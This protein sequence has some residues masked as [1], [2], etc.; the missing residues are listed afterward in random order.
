M[1]LSRNDLSVIEGD[2]RVSC[3]R[4]SEALGFAKIG[5]LHHLIKQHREELE[6]FG[7]LFLNVQKKSSGRGRPTLSYY[8]NEHQAVAICLWAQTAKAREARRQIIDVF[9]AWRHGELGTATPVQSTP[10]QDVFK[11]SAERSGHVVNHLDNIRAMDDLALNVARLPIWP[12]GR[13]PRWWHDLEVREFLTLCHRQMGCQEAEAIGKDR[14]GSRCPG[15]STINMYWQRLDQVY[16]LPRQ[17]PRS[18]SNARRLGG[19]S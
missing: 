7:G 18:H 4:L 1:S 3:R 8:L 6:D 11:F 9:V 19:H 16:G 5:N 12:S 13:R 2:A 10:T 15:K 14:F 17:R